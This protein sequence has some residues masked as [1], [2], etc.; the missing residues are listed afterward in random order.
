MYDSTT[1][2]P[3][4]QCNH[5]KQQF[6]ATP[7][8]FY[9]DKANPSGLRPECKS[10]GLAAVK[11]YQAKHPEKVR[12][13]NKRQ[14][15]ENREQQQAR[16]RASRAKNPQQHRDENKRYRERHAEE[17]RERKRKYRAVNESTRKARKT[18]LPCSLTTAEWERCLDYWQHC[19]AVCGRPVGLWHTLAREHWI[20]L[21]DPRPDNPGTVATNIVPLCHGM[22]GCNNSK[23]NRD[24]I[25]WL[26]ER[27]GK[28][29]AK[30]IT[31]RVQ[32]YFEWVREL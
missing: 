21:S 15:A 19:C 20:A 22:G 11:A 3:L 32:R 24:A 7:E 10:C 1:T 23:H 17:V 5:C 9:R 28:R 2:P 27:Y 29:K 26:T 4:K 14:W 6:P 13:A 31:Q 18:G 30:Q 8:F 16:K 12:A 25:E